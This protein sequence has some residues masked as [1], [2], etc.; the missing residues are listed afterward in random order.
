MTQTTIDTGFVP[1]E[2]DPSD[3]ANIEPLLGELQARDL[4]DADAVGRWLAD[5][6]DLLEAV[7]EYGS[8]ANINNACHT[9]DE[10]IE[11]VYL[12]FVE[13]VQP[14]LKP[15]LF[16]LQKKYIATEHRAAFRGV[17]YETL[18]REWRVDV[19]LFHEANVPLET[20]EVKLFNEYSK[21]CGAMTVE[22]EGETLTLQQLGRYQED[23]D[24]AKRENAWRLGTARRLEDRDKI[25]AIFQTMLDERQQIAT[26]A[27]FGG[28][29]DYMWKRK[30]R[31]DYSPEDCLAFGDAVADL[32]VPLNNKLDAHRREALGVETLRPWDTAVDLKGRPP[33][34][35]FNE[36]DIEGFVATTRAVFERI[37]PMLAEQFGRLKMGDN[38]DLDSRLGKRPG[39]FQA[40]LERSRQPFIFMN[41][42]GL[43]R[44]VE[45]LLHE[46]GHAFHYIASC[47]EPL[48]FLRHAPLEF[49]E[50]ASMSMELLG[51]DHFDA[52]YGSADEAARAKRVHLEGTLR[53]LPW[54]ATIDGYQHWL[55]TH[56]GHT[57]SERTDEWN[58]LLD[59]F[60]SAEV[61]WAGL[62]DERDAMWHRQLHLFGV[63]FYY[64]EYGIAQLGALGAWLNYKRDPEGALADLLKAFSLG[65][66]APLP[67]LFET[68]GVP[69]RF[70][71]E[72]IGPL[73]EAIEAELA[74]LPE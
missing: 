41:A 28:Y 33:L 14:K 24:R 51:M 56:Q 29:R 35:P 72:T 15:A 67:T 12:G 26:N 61:G 58:R 20:N 68:A 34:R 65:G 38:L 30:Y 50:V 9:D 23:T 53:T 5:L 42:A 8:K 45:T 11:R 1:A 47:A 36:K 73:V 74:T 57:L 10:A 64:I 7:Y 48:L 54:I 27:G 21:L 46:A 39:G 66:S 60:G 6:S 2:F 17:R 62:T 43:Q 25:D 22:F 71:A 37:S 59:R 32:I 4:P 40:S 19:E 70:D 52:Y 44:D 49:C 69:F 31:F 18:D 16:E 3:F 13:H 63:P 55:Y